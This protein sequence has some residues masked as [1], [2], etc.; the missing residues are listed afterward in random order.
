MK[1]R[2]P[3]IL[4][5]DSVK[6]IIANPPGKIVRW[7]TTFIFLVLAIILF[8]AWVIRYP[9]IVPS[10][11]EITT[12]NPPVTLVSKITGRINILY[13]KDGENV[14]NGKL[15]AVMET[16]ASIAEVTK[17]KQTVDTITRPDFIS[18]ASLPVFSELGEIQVYWGS[19]LKSLSD[20]SN[21]VT[22]DFYGFKITSTTE[23]IA[24]IEEYI[25]RVMVKERLYVENKRLE[26]KKYARDSSLFISGVFSESELEKSRQTLNRINIEL[27]DVRLDHSAKSIELAEKK[28][29]LQDYK[30]KKIEDRERF[31]SVLNESLLNLKA[32][33]KFWENTYLLVS[34]VSGV[35]AFTKFWTGN[36]LV[37]KDEPVLSIVPLETGD[38]VGR[39]N[40]KMQRSG[41]V[42]PDQPVNIKLS[43]YPYLEYGM[44]RGIVKS[45][46]LVP[47]GDAYVIEIAL[48]DGLTTLYGKKLEFNQNMQGTAEIMTD[49]L[50]LIQK[51]INPFRHLASKNRI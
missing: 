33:I 20:F 16:T 17:L 38:F 40:L 19:F 31:Y 24:A 11:V 15:L 47:T 10:P 22:N 37:M 8:F 41:K 13:V 5:S 18:S 43:G 35:V 14:E 36:Q 42:Q 39:V 25:D 12:V 1:N 28:Q 44:I 9:D 6:E 45:K 50:R 46:S 34:Q 2:M 26:T 51:I 49:D 3:E 4:Y 29:L 32:Q 27:Q 21:Y 30:I 7:G 23:E 48:P